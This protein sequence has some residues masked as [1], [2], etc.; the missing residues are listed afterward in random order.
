[1]GKVTWEVFSSHLGL[2]VTLKMS[3]ENHANLELE[4]IEIFVLACVTE[5]AVVFDFPFK[6]SMLTAFLR[7][8]ITTSMLL[9]SLK[10]DCKSL[11][12]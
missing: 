5:I 11:N 8:W 4:E 1:M 12:A 10:D 9:I 2:V 6:S 7:K 3:L